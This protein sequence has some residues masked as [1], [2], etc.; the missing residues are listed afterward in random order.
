MAST[1]LLQVAAASQLSSLQQQVGEVQARVSGVASARARAAA[2]LAAAEERA[3]GVAGRL[4][5]VEAEKK[6]A[7]AKKVGIGMSIAKSSLYMFLL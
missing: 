6:V 2:E 3:A 1:F 5:E 4:P 7:A